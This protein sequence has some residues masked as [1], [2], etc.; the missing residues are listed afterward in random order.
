M[1]T[2]PDKN[3]SKANISKK[4]L[5]TLNRTCIVLNMSFKNKVVIITGASSG[6]GAA[7]AIQ[8]AKEGA[9]VVLVGR[10][11]ER[12]QNV[13]QV[14]SQ[15]GGKHLQI[16]ADVTV[17]EDLQRIVQETVKTFEKIDVLVNNAGI[18]KYTTIADEN[19]FEVFN[20]I[21][22]NNLR[23]TVYLTHLVAPY[24]IKTKGNIVNVASVAGSMPPLMP[25]MIIYASAKAALIHFT[26]GAAAELATKGVRVNAV[27]PGPVRTDLLRK[28]GL[29][30][31]H[32]ELNL[33]APV[34][35]P[36]TPEEVADLI[37]FMASDRAH[38]ING[39]ELL[40]DKGF[41]TQAPT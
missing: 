38:T 25:V 24:L 36:S 29:N 31:S 18:A 27:S 14:C 13:F 20:A 19:I 11:P 10:N 5:L 6:T 41:K 28:A 16:K 33:V 22:S 40:A 30:K 32:E 15:F 35:S 4:K 9:N 12:L 37:L 34:G 26:Q 7:T 2:K 3:Q 21:Y 23:G 17:K 39:T 8:F 1:K